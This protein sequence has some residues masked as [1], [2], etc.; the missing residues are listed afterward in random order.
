MA[1]HV[2]SIHEYIFG[3]GGAVALERRGTLTP[4]S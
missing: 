4:G 3:G 2:F 1:K